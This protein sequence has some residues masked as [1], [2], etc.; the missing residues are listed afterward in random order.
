[1]TWLT[2]DDGFEGV[3]G[4]DDELFNS[5]WREGKLRYDSTGTRKDVIDEV[6]ARLICSS[7]D[8]PTGVFFLL[9]DLRPHRPALLLATAVLRHWYN[10]Q[11]SCVQPEI[12]Y[13]GTSTGIRDQLGRVS[14]RGARRLSLG[15]VFQ[16]HD[17][18]REGSRLQNQR[19]R[20][21]AGGNLPPVHTIYSPADAASIIHQHP[22]ASMIAIDCGDAATLPWIE[23][24]LTA[25]RSKG[26]PTVAWGQNHLA[27]YVPFFSQF[28]NV[29]AWTPASVGR[30]NPPTT[31][32][33][34]STALLKY[35]LPEVTPVIVEGGETF[36]ISGL[37]RKAAVELLRVSRKAHG[38][39]QGDTLRAHWRYLRALER[40]SVP[41]DFYEIEAPHFWGLPSIAQL[42]RT[43]EHFAEAL[44]Q[45]D[46]KLSS[47]L[48]VARSFL[49]EACELLA[50]CPPL[51]DALCTAAMEDRNGKEAHLIV[52]P[53]RSRMRLFLYALL[54]RHGISEQDLAE[55]NTWVLSLSDLRS[56]I[57][58]NQ[59]SLEVTQHPCPEIPMDAT[60]RLL[61]ASL[62]SS[63]TMPRLLPALRYSRL[64]V[65]L[66]AHQY[67][68]LR[69]R[70]T[71][72]SAGL[73]VGQTVNAD[74]LRVL[75]P[76]HPLI[77][78][79][80][81]VQEIALAAPAALEVKTLA[82]RDTTSLPGNSPL[83]AP[84]NNLEE[85]SRLLDG[86][87]YGQEIGSVGPSRQ[88]DTSTGGNID[89]SGN[90]WCE[91]AIEII[92]TANQ[93]ILF[94]PNEQVQM[95]VASTSGKCAMQ[96][97]YVCS[98]KEGNRV[99]II[100]GQRRQN[101]Y[102]MIVSRVHTMPAIQLHLALIQKWHDDFRASYRMWAAHLPV[103]SRDPLTVLLDEIKTKGSNI[104]C[105]LSLWNWLSG[106]VQCPQDREDL[107]RVSE[108]LDIPFVRKNWRKIGEAASRISG[109]HR[110]L[111]NRLNR[112]LENA[113]QGRFDRNDSEIV[114]PELG[115]TFGDFRSS[116]EILTVK[117]ANE[118]PGPFLR[119]SLGIVERSSTDE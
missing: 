112:W 65:L 62:P 11:G 24:L 97:R 47:R 50:D 37:L 93:R 16:Q 102:D 17:M 23:S 95:I 68:A 13:F 25:A 82:R 21:D 41:L 8:K 35:N 103:S 69:A 52:F 115:L 100:H 22:Y 49:D 71:T 31:T 76:T 28:S 110:G 15:D 63:A 72:W 26:I 55:F 46:A 43:S 83:M 66:H 104:T 48:E 108:A 20:Q 74:A 105:T 79:V 40:L 118:I 51:W 116:L 38:R 96:E 98:L 10:G 86:R 4:C 7:L 73:T 54:A 91:T 6:N 109:I 29:I 111:S 32:D 3:H 9:P 27:E 12:L 88:E 2:V 61:L 59:M 101:L 90:G 57:H 80:A 64:E 117:S 1:M 42:R 30:D 84:L 113:V 56:L 19:N 53:S 39:L 5:L 45:S 34:A 14:V 119:S 77:G 87:D 44:Q 99:V 107:R 18:T 114:D 58:W 36:K 85:V 106:T 78:E 60:H 94:P 92:S 89:E 81:S 67:S 70:C 75:A 33:E